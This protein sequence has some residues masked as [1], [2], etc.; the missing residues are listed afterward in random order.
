[1]VE[2][3]AAGLA[4][5]RTVERLPAAAS[6]FGCESQTSSQV[7]STQKSCVSVALQ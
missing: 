3:G 5:V 1:V 4:G 2:A 7:P 6:R